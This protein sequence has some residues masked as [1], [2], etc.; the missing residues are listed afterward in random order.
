MA[1]W[2][3]SK[4]QR[5]VLLCNGGSCTRKGGEMVTQAVRQE[6]TRLGADAVV[7]TSK[8]M[9]NGRCDDACVVIVYPDGVWYHSITP[10][11]APALVEGHLLRGIPLEDKVSH[12]HH[13]NHFVRNEAVPPGKLK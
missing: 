3:F 11:D 6:I 5:H 12:H 2:D 10:E 1:T 7:H 4:T 8:T 9:C 13:G